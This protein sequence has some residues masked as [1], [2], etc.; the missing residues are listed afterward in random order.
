MVQEFENN[1]GTKPDRKSLDLEKYT[2]HVRASPLQQNGY[3]C[4]MFVIKYADFRSRIRDPKSQHMPPEAV[5]GQ[6]KMSYYRQKTAL[7]LV[8]GRWGSVP[9]QKP[10][11]IRDTVGAQTKKGK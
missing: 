4:G 5:F 8:S 2:K 6:S 10:T 7:E 9:G 11:N 3:D 1:P